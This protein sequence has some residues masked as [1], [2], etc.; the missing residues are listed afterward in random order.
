MVR[1]TPKKQLAR[2]RMSTSLDWVGIIH[3]F[4]TT[5]QR[6]WVATQGRR[7]KWKQDMAPATQWRYVKARYGST[8]WRTWNE[9]TPDRCLSHS[10]WTGC[11]V[12]RSRRTTQPRSGA[13]MQPRARA[14]GRKWD[15]S[16]PCR[17]EREVTA[18]IRQARHR[19][20]DSAPGS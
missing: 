12:E 14:L 4:V 6:D 16:Q 8:G 2:L 5:A 13:R 20:Y 15:R 19:S 9:A 1:Q 7:T 3:Q 18:Q 10:C 17:G 11:K